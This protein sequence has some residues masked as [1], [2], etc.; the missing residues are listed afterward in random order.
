MALSEKTKKKVQKMI[1][2]RAYEIEQKLSEDNFFLAKLAG[3][4]P[5]QVSDVSLKVA[6]KE[7]KKKMA[8]E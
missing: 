2:E 3:L 4:K 5:E 6:V 8:E 1:F 7:L